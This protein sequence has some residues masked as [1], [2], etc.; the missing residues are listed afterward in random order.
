MNF[1]KWMGVLAIAVALYILWQ[2]RQLLLLLFTAV[3]IANALNIPVRRFERSGMARGYAIALTALILGV[4]AAMFFWAIVPPFVE[5]LQ[6]LAQL[7]PLAIEELSDWIEEFETRFRPEIIE[8]LPDLEQLVQQIQPLAEPLLGGGVTFFANSL[9]VLLNVL[10]VAVLTLMLLANPDSYR[11][12]FVRLFP[13]F[14]RRRV[15]RILSKCEASLQGW[16]AGILFNMLVITI[17][18]FIGLTLLGIDL[19]LSQALLAGLLTFIPN[20]GPFLSV[21]PPMAIALLETPWKSLAVLALYIIIQQVEGNIL[22][23]LVMAQQVALLPAITLLAQVFFAVFFGFLGLLLAL[24]LTV[25]GQVWVKE[26]LIKDIL[27]NWQHGEYAPPRPGSLPPS[28]P[29]P[30]E[31]TETVPV[32]QPPTSASDSRSQWEERPSQ[33]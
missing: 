9:G 18:S 27:D 30:M 6:Q 1:G 7:V 31:D 5:Q 20:I 11:R 32:A 14:Y 15:D 19:A 16:L 3:V 2:I 21:I 8:A 10:L 22:T 33:E 12:G 29:A 17:L 4:V 25:V 24:P 26:A 23:P 13:S 28:P